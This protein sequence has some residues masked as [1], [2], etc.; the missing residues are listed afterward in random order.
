[1]WEAVRAVNKGL[2]ESPMGAASECR[3]Y[4]WHRRLLI[5][6]RQGT[7]SFNAL[8]LRSDQGYGAA[9]VLPSIDEWGE[10]IVGIAAT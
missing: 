8:D 2:A 3:G 6:L 5:C 7:D 9:C 4:T 1:M 10:C